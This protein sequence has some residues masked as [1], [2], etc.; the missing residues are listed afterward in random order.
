MSDSNTTFVGAA[1]VIVVREAVHV[2]ESLF[3]RIARLRLSLQIT[4]R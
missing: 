2:V 4:S 3:I 1:V